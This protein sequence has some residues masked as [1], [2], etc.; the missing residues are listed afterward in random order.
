ML[1]TVLLNGRWGNVKGNCDRLPIV[2]GSI[3]SIEHVDLERPADLVAREVLE[4]RERD[5][6]V[7]PGSP[8]DEGLEGPAGLRVAALRLTLDLLALR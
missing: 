2:A 6:A 8:R 1:L 7:G 5:E 4:N 3:D